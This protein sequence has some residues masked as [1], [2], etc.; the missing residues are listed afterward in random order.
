MK[1]LSITNLKGGVAKTTIAYNLAGVLAERGKR[2]L[3][4][5]MDYQANLTTLFE[6]EEPRFETGANIAKVLLESLP[7]SQA[8]YESGIPNVW[9][10]PAD[11]DL[12][13]LDARYQSDLNAHFLLAE[14][15]EIERERF[16]YVL[17]DCPPHLFLGTRMAL[18][19]SDGYL[20][21]VAADRFSLRAAMHVLQVAENIRKRANR[22]LQLLGIVMTRV[23][24]RR[25]SDQ[26]LEIFRE[27][28]NSKLL[29]TQIKE[30]TVIQEAATHGSPISV[31]EPKGEAAEMFRSLAN[32]IHL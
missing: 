21:P 26:Y 22:D 18:V 11:I 4:I 15:L 32:E 8:I 20:V 1:V 6:G 9:L 10:V 14:L 17:I 23:M 5:D 19:A 13:L 2:V 31:F 27:H 7:L 16:D 28:F 29:T 12:S 3:L 24:R 25:V 30:R